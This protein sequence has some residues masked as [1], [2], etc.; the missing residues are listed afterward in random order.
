MIIIRQPSFKHLYEDTPIQEMAYSASTVEQKL[1]ANED[2]VFVHLLK[3]FYF[4]DFPQ[5]FNGWASSVAKMWR[6]YKIK[7]NTSKDIYPSAQTILDWIWNNQTDSFE[8]HHDAVLKNFNN[9]SLDDYAKLPYV[10]AGGDVTTAA[11]FMQDYYYWL[12]KELSSKGKIS[13]GEVQDR[14]KELLRKY[15]Y[16]GK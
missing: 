15:P 2:I 13:V 9:K 8:D 1:T 4:Q 11:K 7:K 14:L 5:Y 10:H 3:I 6:V 12:A 16:K